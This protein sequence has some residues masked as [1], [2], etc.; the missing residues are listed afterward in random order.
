VSNEKLWLLLLMVTP[1]Q[2]IQAQEVKHA[3]T[4]AQCRADQKLWFSKLG[5]PGAVP[6]FT[7]P[8]P[9]EMWDTQS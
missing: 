8:E 1:L 4:A 3:T 6:S 7:A 2:L 9:A 5:P